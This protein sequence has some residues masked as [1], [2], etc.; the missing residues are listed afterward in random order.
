MVKYITYQGLG[1]YLV[2]VMNPN[3]EI[4]ATFKV[5]RNE[6]LA[7]PDEFLDLLKIQNQLGEDK[8]SEV[9]DEKRRG[10]VR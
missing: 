6:H 2:A 7:I 4:T 8:M 10:R 3:G 1:S 9:S 5:R